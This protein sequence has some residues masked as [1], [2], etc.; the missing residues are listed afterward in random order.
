[1]SKRIEPIHPDGL[2]VSATPWWDEIDDHYK[3]NGCMKNIR[4][5]VVD[6]ERVKRESET[7]VAELER[8][9]LWIRRKI[10]DFAD[11]LREGIESLP[12][13]DWKQ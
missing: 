11:R 9:L 7:R 10:E 1:M 5:E 12:P 6:L 3:R 4:K 13:K 2:P 8:E